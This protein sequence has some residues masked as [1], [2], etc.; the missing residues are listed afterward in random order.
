MTGLIQ[1]NMSD[2]KL[3]S[4]GD[5]I[6]PTFCLAKRHHTTIYLHTGDTHS[7]YHPSPH[8]ISLNEMDFNLNNINY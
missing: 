3:E 6:S 2:T 5:K 1:Y 8:K 7:C 4:P